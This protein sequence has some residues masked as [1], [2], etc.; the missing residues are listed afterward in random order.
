MQTDSDFLLFIKDAIESLSLIKATL[1]SPFSKGGP[2]KVSIQ[3]VTVK[4]SQIFQCTLFE[5]SQAFHKN[6]LPSLFFEEFSRLF[7]LFKQIHLQT[8]QKE[9]HVLKNKKGGFS[10][11]QKNLSL[12][13]SPKSHNREKEYLIQE[14]APLAF[15]IALG[16]SDAKGT[17]IRAKSDKFRQLNR[18]LEMVDS[19]LSALPKDKKLTFID[20]G[21]GKSYLTFALYHFLKYVKGL[22]LH[23]TG[24]DLKKEVIE[25][26]QKLAKEIGYEEGLSFVHGDIKDFECESADCVISLHACNTAT[27]IALAKAVEWQASL[28]L[29]VPCCQNELY[30]QIKSP[31]LQPILK[32]GILKERLS[33]IATDAM[34]AELLEL[35]GYETAIIE[36]IDLEHTP[37]NLLIRAVKNKKKQKNKEPH[38]ESYEA[39]K[40]FLS[41]SPFLEKILFPH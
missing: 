40:Q 30:H 11:R 16:L 20:F 18:F 28:I 35:A 39:L 32:H 8:A 1:S 23:I 4:N 24:I 9:V 15:L 3:L 26:C 29:A 27:D 21:C 10:L 2:S 31:L 7:A 6:Y 41:A 5:N 37:K 38:K 17:I 22:S 19:C 13:I 33:A 12:P 25:N 36:F 34:R 14:G